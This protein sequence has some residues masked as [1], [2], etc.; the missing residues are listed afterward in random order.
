[1][2]DGNVLC[3]HPKLGLGR[4]RHRLNIVCDVVVAVGGGGCAED[5]MFHLSYDLKKSKANHAGLFVLA[6]ACVTIPPTLNLS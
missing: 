4:V 2:L 5:E 1:M 3:F 6:S